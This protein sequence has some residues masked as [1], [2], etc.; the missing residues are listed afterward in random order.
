LKIFFT[1]LFSVCCFAKSQGQNYF[2]YKAPKQNVAWIDSMK[3][4]I[5][6]GF[7]V[8]EKKKNNWKKQ[9]NYVNSCATLGR[10]W[11]WAYEKRFVR[12]M[13]LALKYYNIIINLD[14]FPDD[15]R[16]FKAL[17]IRTSLF[18]KLA[19]IYFKG[20]GVK[21]DKKF[22][23]AYALKGIR[24]NKEMYNFYS[25][26]YFN[27]TSIFLNTLKDTKEVKDSFYV[28]KV[29]PFYTRVR[30]LKV[31]NLDKRL[32]II[33]EKFKECFNKKI[34]KILIEGTCYSSGSAQADM[35][36]LVKKL[37]EWFL[38][39]TSMSEENIITNVEVSDIVDQITI[40][41]LPK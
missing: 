23:L 8:D 39:N 20:K 5:N 28:L 3:R 26:R 32:I 33:K 27:S 10:Y 31:I 24:Y 13:Q 38:N 29:N 37:I 35:H 7:E 16:Y 19:D 1:I 18:R 12:N 15:E 30:S 21:K 14:R 22:S 6:K 34:V 41:I 25:L 17:A 9:L 11:E 4:I 2:P 40:K 36:Y